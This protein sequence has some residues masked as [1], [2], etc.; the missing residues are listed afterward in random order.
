MIDWSAFLLVLVVTV[1]A[2]LAIVSV[3]GLGIRLLA[4][5]T[6]PGPVG[7]ATDEEEDDVNHNGRPLIA[8]I[9]AWVSFVAFAAI[10]LYGIWLIVPAFH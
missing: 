9:F 6:R 10:V 2:S 3:V 1:V 5:P 8:T 7:E 4:V